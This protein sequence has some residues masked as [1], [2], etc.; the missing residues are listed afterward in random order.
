M[1][2]GWLINYLYSVCRAYPQTSEFR[3][4]QEATSS[5]DEEAEAKE[6]K[7]A[8]QRSEGSELRK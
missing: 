7:L 2:L 1:N 6:R 3:H 4:G 8:K 5:D